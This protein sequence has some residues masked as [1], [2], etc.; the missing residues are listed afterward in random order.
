MKTTVSSFLLQEQYLLISPSS[1]KRRD[2]RRLKK[3]VRSL[4]RQAVYSTSSLP[5][6]PSPETTLLSVTCAY[7]DP[8]KTQLPQPKPLPVAI[9][10]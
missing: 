2:I 1:V 3:V 5:S 4:A 6:I 10:D 7:V 8:Q 9:L